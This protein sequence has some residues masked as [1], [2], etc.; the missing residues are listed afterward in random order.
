MSTQIDVTSDHLRKAFEF[1]VKYFLNPKKVI[2]G[3]TS[4]QERRLGQIIDDFITGKVRELGVVD[5]LRENNPK[6]EFLIDLDVHDY[7]EYEDPDIVG[8]KQNNS[9]R[10]P[11]AF[12]EIK[13]NDPNARWTG[14]YSEQFETI[15]K[16]DLVKNNLKNLY[17][18]YASLESKKDF[19]ER[20]NDLFGIFLKSNLSKNP[21]L[22]ETFLDSGD[23][24]IRIDHVI[25][26]QELFDNGEFFLKKDKERGISG[27][28]IWESE[29][30]RE[31]N[32]GIITRTGMRRGVF[33]ENSVNGVLPLQ[34]L[35][36]PSQFGDFKYS[37]KIDA[38]RVKFG[39]SQS[40]Y[41]KCLSDVVVKNKLLGEFHLQ[42]G[43]LY[44]IVIKELMPCARNNLWI[45]QR[46]LDSVTQS[47]EKRIKE[48]AQKI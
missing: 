6:C 13:N 24:R 29:I 31:S 5:I 33:K 19:T 21:A 26:G 22:F 2:R 36:I 14:L 8:V 3:R 41:I 10:K 48:I 4:G 20:T 7:P 15:K 11:K 44:Q 25:T 1:S 27:D 39:N 38:Y 17:I 43:K 9:I 30:F 32:L 16:H 34:N 42:S 40:L 12:I 45:A 18:V 28:S 47:N 46:N 35:S 23:M 37:G